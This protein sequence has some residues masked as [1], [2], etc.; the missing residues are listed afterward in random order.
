MRRGDT[1]WLHNDRL[2]TSER[3]VTTNALGDPYR[4]VTPYADQREGTPSELPQK[5]FSWCSQAPQSGVLFTSP[6]IES[7]H[8][9]RA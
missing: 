7:F 8:A 1:V 2:A 5:L 6:G 3:A 4:N 9:M